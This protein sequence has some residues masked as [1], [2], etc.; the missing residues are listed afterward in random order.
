MSYVEICVPTLLS[1]LEERRILEF[2]FSIL[3]N[4]DYL[5][6]HRNKR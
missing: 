3:N 5:K 2:S 4:N 6:P 1:I